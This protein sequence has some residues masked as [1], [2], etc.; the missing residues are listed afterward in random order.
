MVQ[1][2]QECAGCGSWT[3]SHNVAVDVSERDGA[4]TPTLAGVVCHKCWTGRRDDLPAIEGLLD[5]HERLYE[6]LDTDS[7]VAVSVTTEELLG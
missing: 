4:G 6:A 7:L 1:K 2:P 5:D 3:R